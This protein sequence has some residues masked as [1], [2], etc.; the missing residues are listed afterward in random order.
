MTRSAPT[1]TATDDP[2][3]GALRTLRTPGS[4]P[5]G[6]ALVGALL[7]TTAAVLAFASVRSTQHGPDGAV[8]VAVGPIGPGERL[9]ADRLEVVT[10]DVP[11]ALAERTY[12][13]IDDVLDAVAV[14]ALADGDPVLR[15][16]VVA[17]DQVPGGRRVVSFSLDRDRALDG[18]LQAGEALDLLATYGTGES[19]VTQVVARRAALVRVDDAARGGL[20]SAGK[21]TVVVGLPSDEEVVRVAHASQVAA[22]TLV[23]SVDPTST[24]PVP[25]ARTPSAARGTPAA[26]GSTAPPAAAGGRAGA[27]GG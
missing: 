27:G 23:R 1:P 20:A 3:A 16:S 11:G 22:V 12:G 24:E 5:S 9:T 2:P 18:A 10:V 4:L 25:E 17:A 8:V 14:G 13:R 19:A 7:V 15:S 6:R 21:I 26:P